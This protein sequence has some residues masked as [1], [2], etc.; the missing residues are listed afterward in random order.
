MEVK[1]RIKCDVILG[2]EIIHTFAMFISKNMDYQNLKE[3]ESV[4]TSTNYIS[5][6]FFLPVPLLLAFTHLCQ[7][8]RLIG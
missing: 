8:V 7:A 2:Q 1:K 4:I 6:P 5:L 3:R